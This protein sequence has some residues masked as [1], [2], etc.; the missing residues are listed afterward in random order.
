[1]ALIVLL[2]DDVEPVEA[3]VSP[4]MRSLLDLIEVTF[5]PT[6][7]DPTALDSLARL[8]GAVPMAR[9][10]LGSVDAACDQIEA[11]LHDLLPQPAR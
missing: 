7:E 8:V 5:G 1:M 4:T 9:L 2:T 10:R 6:F 3:P 11:A